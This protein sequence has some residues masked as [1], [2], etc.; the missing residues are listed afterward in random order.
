MTPFFPPASFVRFLDRE[1][2]IMPF[3]QLLF[4][5]SGTL[6]EAPV[7]DADGDVLAQPVLADITGQWVQIFL[8]P[9]I[10]YRVRLLTALGVE[11]GDV[12]PIPELSA[13]AVLFLQRA[14]GQ[15]T[16]IERT[17]QDKG[18]ELLTSADFT[19]SAAKL[20]GVG[21]DTLAANTTGFGNTAVGYRALKANTTGDS[22][23]A[24]GDDALLSNTTGDCN[25]AVGS[26]ALAQNVD[27]HTNVAVG[28]NA[29][30]GN[31]HGTNN[32][33]V[34]KNA[35]V[36]LI[37]TA[38]ES[39]NNTAIGDSAMQAMAKGY[40]NVA[41]GSDSLAR[42]SATKTGNTAIGTEALAFCST[43][44]NNAAL[45]THCFFNLTTGNS[46]IGAGYYTGDDLLTGNFNTL[47]GYQTG[48]GI[49]SGSYNTILGAQVS[50]LAAGTANNVILADGA[51]TIRY[52]W[53]GATNKLNGPL[54]LSDTPQTL[55]GAGAVNITSS[56]TWL[57][58]NAANALTLADGAEGQIKYIIM[59]TDGGDGTLTPANFGNGSTITFNDVGDSAHLLFTNAKWYFMGGTATVA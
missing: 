29:L 24:V 14:I 1:G 27:G 31:L 34:G 18:Y 36:A 54:R 30:N 13:A 4:Y 56:I 20:T 51:G 21:T 11:E 5:L 6:T 46:N 35:L 47:L 12:D 8:D 57:V 17:L 48:G 28:I 40:N 3:G 19:G 44:I 38:L 50:G 41:I 43:G 52:H 55:T 7:Y 59:K 9:D 22:Q 15:G 33:G 42:S 37:G 32:V 23:V 26:G 39:N 16:P 53:D 45:G 25:T 2:Q 10:A 58:T 49:V